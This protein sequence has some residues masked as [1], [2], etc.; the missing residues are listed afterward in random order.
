VDHRALTCPKPAFLHPLLE[1]DVEQLLDVRAQPRSRR[2]PQFDVDEMPQW[3]ADTGI[4]YLHGAWAGRTTR[5]PGRGPD[6]QCRLAQRQF[7]ELRR[8]PLTAAYRQGVQRLQE[9]AADRR[10]VIVCGEPMPWRCHRLLIANTL[11]A[12]GWPVWHM[13]GDAP[14]RPHQLGQW[15]AA[16]V[17][18]PDL[19]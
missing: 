12:R 14:P 7:Q 4:G 9:L 2:S 8:L 18:G 19:R 15:G 13:L 10:T 1:Q 11:A 5:A 16:P 17:I 6:A 3:L